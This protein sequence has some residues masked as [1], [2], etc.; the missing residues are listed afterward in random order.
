MFAFDISTRFACSTLL[1]RSMALAD[2]LKAISKTKLGYVDLWS[3]PGVLQHVDP[4]RDSVTDVTAL[5]SDHN[6]RPA[7][8]SAYATFGDDLA[9]VG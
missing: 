5:L 2:V 3:T 8:V 7:S 9:G 6:I 4:E 1:F